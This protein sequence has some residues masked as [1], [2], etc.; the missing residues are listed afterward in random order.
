MGTDFEFDPLLIETAIELRIRSAVDRLAHRLESDFRR[1]ADRIYAE[2]AVDAV[3]EAK[4]RTVYHSLFEK[5]GYPEV[6][7]ES[8]AD[9]PLITK[10]LR[11]IVVFQA[12]QSGDEGADLPGN[13]DA[14]AGNNQAALYI[15]AGSL[16]DGAKLDSFLK[17]SWLQLQDLVNP[18]FVYTG[19]AVFA[20][21]HPAEV[22]QLT[23]AYSLLWALYA[24]YRMRKAGWAATDKYAERLSVLDQLS[25]GQAA[26]FQPWLDAH[27]TITH[28]HLAEAAR[29]LQQQRRRLR[30]GAI[31]EC[32]FCGFPAA[33]FVMTGDIPDK[34]ILK[35]AIGTF[36]PD[37][38]GAICGQCQERLEIMI[39][40]AGAGHASQ[41][42][43]SRQEETSLGN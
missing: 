4:F 8:L 27:R 34:G 1:Q 16:T 21:R 20:G 7:Q 11:K 25:G 17:F 5:L 3:R 42:Q 6:F 33:E 13:Q 38:H 15:T 18:E 23:R 28:E 39:T 19:D 40:T 30:S 41:H 2:T 31:C 32:G 12:R 37:V 10:R 9:F 29:G 22:Q 24:D 14:S 26:E 43:E 36:Y 35:D